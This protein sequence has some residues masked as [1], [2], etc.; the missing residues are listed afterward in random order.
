MPRMGLTPD[1]VVD[2]AAKIADRVGIEELS[3]SALAAD[4]G[5]RVPSLYKHV[6]GIDD[7]QQRLA[8]QGA[9]GLVAAAET[10][11][12]GKR[13]RDQLIA[14]GIAYRRYAHANRGR[15]QAL[16]RVSGAHGENPQRSAQLEAV[17]RW[18]VSQYG[19]NVEE[20]RHAA[21]AVRSALHGFV[22]LEANGTFGS[23]AA[24][25]ASFAGLMSLLERGLA[26]AP[27]SRPRGL[28]LPSLG[29]PSH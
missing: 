11:A 18:A 4:L 14:I 16:V 17:L 28:R 9:A 12:R 13:G 25:D 2:A 27:H 15:Y 6:G 8:E 19:L 7:L 23:T 22:L 10:E 24:A 20:T 21:H 26:T 5:V 3:L 29:L 1:K